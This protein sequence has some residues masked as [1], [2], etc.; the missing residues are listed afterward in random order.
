MWNHAA[1]DPRTDPEAAAARLAS[2]KLQAGDQA[3]FLGRAHYG[4]VAT[5]QQVHILVLALQMCCLH[6]HA[7]WWPRLGSPDRSSD[8]ALGR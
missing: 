5:V 6:V 2:V 8:V 1:Q 4:C 3:L 7:A